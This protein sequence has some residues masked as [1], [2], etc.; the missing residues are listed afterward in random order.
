[1]APPAC[2]WAPDAAAAAPTTRCGGR[3]VPSAEQPVDCRQ[4]APRPR[5]RRTSAGTEST[6][7][8]HGLNLCN[9]GGRDGALRILRSVVGPNT[10]PLVPSV[11]SGASQMS[12]PAAT[13]S[14]R[15]ARPGA[16]RS[17]CPRARPGC[18]CP[19]CCTPPTRPPTT[20]SAGAA[21]TCCPTGGVPE[22]RAL[23]HPHPRRRRTRRLADQLGAR[24]RHRTARPRRVARRADR[25]VR[26]A[27]RIPLGRRSIAAPTARG[28]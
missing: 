16:R 21:T 25:A 13:S 8:A 24:S 9:T 15:C 3:V 10:P 17:R 7:P 6:A 23:V 12:L 27:E 18:G 1:M 20:C 14:L 4:T 2:R 19:T 26:F 28:R 5:P 11:R 22:R